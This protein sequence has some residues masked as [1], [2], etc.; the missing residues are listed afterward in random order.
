MFCF[1][2]ILTLVGPLNDKIKSI[3]IISINEL[4][5]FISLYRRL[6]INSRI[7]MTNISKTQ[8]GI[9]YIS[10]KNT[11]IVNSYFFI[12]KEKLEQKLCKIQL[13][14]IVTQIHFYLWINDNIFANH[15]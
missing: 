15:I 6:K 10:N 9:V 3:G 11:T 14:S 13:G 12:N 7:M 8:L 4:F 1:F 2:H 5:T